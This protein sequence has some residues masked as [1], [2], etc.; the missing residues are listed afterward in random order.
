[1]ITIRRIIAAVSAAILLAA[2]AGPAWAGEFNVDK[3]GSIV[4][5]PSHV[6]PLASPVQSAPPTIV[7]IATAGG[8]NWG[9]AAIGAAAGVAIAFLL[10][11]GG[12][13]LTQRGPGG[14]VGHA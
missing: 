10:V 6:S 11:G 5:V 4:R 3:Q 1:M 8:F 7:H 9:D 13:V 12:L 2:G 14:H